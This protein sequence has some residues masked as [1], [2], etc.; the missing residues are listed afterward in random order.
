MKEITKVH[1]SITKD[2]E[3]LFYSMKDQSKKVF[4]LH[5]RSYIPFPQ[6]VLVMSLLPLCY[7]SSF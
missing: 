4:T 6:S 1:E 3:S 5:F 2:Y 7:I